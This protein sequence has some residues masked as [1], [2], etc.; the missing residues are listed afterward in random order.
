MKIE[1]R[2]YNNVLMEVIVESD[3]VNVKEDVA[4]YKDGKAFVEESLIDEFFNV[5]FDL[6][7]FNNR[8]DVDTMYNLTQQFLSDGEQEELK[9]L[10]KDKQ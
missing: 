8:S 1:T 4:R 2:E 10:L 3:N 5:G 7:N 6:S 9:E